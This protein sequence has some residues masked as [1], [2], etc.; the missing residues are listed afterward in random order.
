MSTA[1]LPRLLHVL[2]VLS[3]RGLVPGTVLADELGVDPRT[4][5]RDV[6]RLRGLGHQVEAVRGRHGGYR[7]PRSRRLPP[8]VLE[9]GQAVAVVLGIEAV[10]RAGL[11]VADGSALADRLLRLLPHDV[12]G[13]VAAL[14]QALWDDLPHRTVTGRVAAALLLDV[15]TAVRDGTAVRMRYVDRRGRPSERTVDP[16][17]VV[18]HAG[19]WYV[20]GHDHR[21]DDARIFRVDRIAAVLAAGPAAVGRPDDLDLQAHVREQLTHDAWTHEV[22]VELH[23][24]MGE[25]RRRV[26]DALGDLTEDDGR[27]L[28]RVGA[29]DLAGMA[30]ALASLGLD[31]TVRRPAALR[32]E[33]ATL[34]AQLA[35]SAARTPGGTGPARTS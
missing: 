21:A 15:G 10:R 12:A 18:P 9:D 29:N 26:P 34:G 22:E 1:V 5:R 33:L 25:A 2:E 6:E 16:W 3:V 8:L 32:A 35:A 7:L 4:L 27:V 11:D 17:G 23:T 13:R 31:V 24:D 28:L 20:V 19:R 14:R 30:R